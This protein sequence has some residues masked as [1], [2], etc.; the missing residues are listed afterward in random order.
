MGFGASNAIVIRCFVRST[1]A[2]VCARTS[3]TTS[4]ISPW[5]ISETFLGSLAQE[6]D[7]DLLLRQTRAFAC[8]RTSSITSLTSA[9]HDGA[10]RK[11]QSA[12][13]KAHVYEL[14]TADSPLSRAAWL[15]DASI[16]FQ[17]CHIETRFP[18][19]ISGFHEQEP[20]DSWT[21]TPWPS[22]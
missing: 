2:F 22:Q 15:K 16:R 3:S 20:A 10:Y 9:W 17:C 11:S 12:P 13:R 14:W 18:Q 4:F 19:S 7:C 8:A 6:R 5:V 1:G 21:S